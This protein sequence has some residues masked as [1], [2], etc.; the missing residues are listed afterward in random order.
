[1]TAVN[2]P[3]N[4]KIATFYDR[5]SG[6]WENVWGEHMHHGYYGPQGKQSKENEQAQVD[7]MDRAL[8][9]AKVERPQQILDVGCGIGGSTL[10]LAD[11]YHAQATG[12]TL[13]PK[14]AERATQRAQTSGCTGSTRFL[15]ADAQQLPLPDS[16]IDLAWSLECAEHVPDRSALLRECSRVLKPGGRL[17]LTTWC[18]RAD[19]PLRRGERWLLNLIRRTYHLAEWVSAERY[20]SLVSEAALQNE[21]IADWS[22]AVAPFWPRVLLKACT[23]AGLLGLLKTGGFAMR[24]ACATSLMCLGY[25]TG[26]IRYVVITARKA[27]D[28]ND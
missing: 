1:M 3:L 20:R 22:Q 15:V 28:E 18:H 8:Q 25:W 10:Y 14:Q 12:I 19:R 7:L 23:P 11:R 13:S 5:C 16:S 26:L 27:A 4:Q 24:A 6:L 2:R 21:R 17:I 9:F